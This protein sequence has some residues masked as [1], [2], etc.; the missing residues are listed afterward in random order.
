MAQGLRVGALT[1]NPEKAARLRALGLAEVIEAELDSEAW[2]AEIRGRYE[3]VVNCVS[4]AGGGLEGYRKSYV[5]GQR[6]ILSWAQ[7]Q[8]IRTYIYTSSSS[9]Y[10]Q[11][12]GVTVDESADTTAAPS[13]GQLILESEA[14]LAAAAD[15]LKH[16][17]VLRL[18]GIYGPGRH[19]LLDQLREGAGEIPGSG[20]YALN[21][22]HR[23]DIVAAIATALGA[24]SA[25]ESGIYNITDNSPATKAEVL[26][27]LAERLGRPAPVFQPE[28]VSERLKRRGGRMP[29]RLVSN[30]KAR[31]QLAWQPRYPSYREGYAALLDDDCT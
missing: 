27:W 10:P 17:F 16:W 9:V 7:S 24:G 11:D 1:R 26:A 4:S 22:I 15:W 20:D 6:S 2:H 13:T 3:A 31:A 5:N 29:H 28:Q 18:T 30:A 23:D 25:V 21:M 19:Y 8:A 12:G 14:H